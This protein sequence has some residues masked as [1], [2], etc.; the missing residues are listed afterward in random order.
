[1]MPATLIISRS[2]L[3]PL[4]VM[5]VRVDGRRRARF[6]RA[7]ARLGYPA[8]QMRSLTGLSDTG[9]KRV[10]EAEAAGLWGHHAGTIAREL[11]RVA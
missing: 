11:A 2:G 1:M 7:L 3:P 10:L 5:L 6:A 4:R 9:L 8:W